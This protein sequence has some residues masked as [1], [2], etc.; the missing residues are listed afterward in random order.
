MVGGFVAESLNDQLAWLTVCSDIIDENAVT[1]F[2]SLGYGVEHP[3]EI[4]EKCVA[5]E[6][7]NA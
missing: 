6:A 3:N 1:E 4:E 5:C 2:K 7:V